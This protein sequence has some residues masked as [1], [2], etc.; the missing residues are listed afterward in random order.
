LEGCPKNVQELYCGNNKLTSLQ[1]CPNSVQD[2]WC[3]SNQLISLQYCPNSVQELWCFHNKLT[4]LQYCPNSVQ[5]LDCS[6]NQLTSLQYCPNSVKKIRCKDNPLNPE[7]AN[8]SHS[9]IISKIKEKNF[10]RGLFL[11]KKTFLSKKLNTFLQLWKMYYL[12]PR[13]IVAE[14]GLELWCPYGDRYLE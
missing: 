1:Y 10:L 14:N 7:W 3:E 2:L 9:Q 4:S 8:L 5:E 11:I 6:N 12:N 13:H